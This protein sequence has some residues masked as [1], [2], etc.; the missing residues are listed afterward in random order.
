MNNRNRRSERP[1]GAGIDA[2]AKRCLDEIHAGVADPT[3]AQTLFTELQP[4][5]AKN[6]VAK[7]ANQMPD[8]PSRGQALAL[9]SLA[10]YL[11]HCTH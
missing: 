9:P 1:S 2:D 6:P 5:L 10:W 7:I 3:F 11:Y 8:T 4:E